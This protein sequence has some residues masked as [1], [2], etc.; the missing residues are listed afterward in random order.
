MP[1]YYKGGITPLVVQW[2]EQETSKLLIQV[3][4]LARGLNDFYLYFGSIDKRAVSSVGRATL[5]HREGRRSES[6][7]AHNVSVLMPAAFLSVPGVFLV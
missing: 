1:W 7:T 3:R 5:L 2:I 4:F 6:C